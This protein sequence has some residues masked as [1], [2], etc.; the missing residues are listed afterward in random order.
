[1]GSDQRDP[2]EKREVLL[3]VRGPREHKKKSPERISFS[4]DDEQEA[5]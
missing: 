5:A 3:I 4:G 2:A 1:M